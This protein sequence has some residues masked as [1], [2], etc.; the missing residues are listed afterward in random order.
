MPHAH[1]TVFMPALRASTMMATLLVWLQF[2]ACAGLIGA[3]GYQ[4]SRYGDADAI[5]EGR[6]RFARYLAEP[7]SLPASL[8]D[9][10]LRIAGR[11]ADAATWEALKRLAEQAPT[12]EEKFRAYR[13]LAEAQDPALAART[14][15]LARDKAVPQIMRNELAYRGPARR[16]AAVRWR[17]VHRRRRRDLRRSGACRSAR[18]PGGGAHARKPDDG[19]PLRRRGAQPRPA[20]GA[21]AAAARGGAR[22]RAAG[23]QAVVTGMRPT[24]LDAMRCCHSAGPVW[25]TLVPFESTATVT[26]MSLTSNS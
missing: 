18:G 19:A 25:C 15:A 9:S 17:L 21:A 24:E 26:G 3:A 6:A 22:R 4:L 13:A 11:H 1:R 5:A 20:E 10:V 7:A 16:R 23:A 14:L 8:V 12:S 2:T